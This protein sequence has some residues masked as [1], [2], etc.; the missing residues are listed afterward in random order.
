MRPSERS[1]AI[2]QG[3]LRAVFRAALRF[4]FLP[5]EMSTPDFLQIHL[6]FLEAR[7]IRQSGRD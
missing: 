2:V 4:V 3:Y 1:M 7:G 6:L 5:S